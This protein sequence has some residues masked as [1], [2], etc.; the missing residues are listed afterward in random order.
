MFTSL[1]SKIISLIIFIMVVTALIIIFISSREI[2]DAMLVQQDSMSRHVLSL[3]ELNIKGEYSDLISEKIYSVTRHKKQ[4]DSLKDQFIKLLDRLNHDV[5]QQ[6]LSMQD[7][8][9]IALDWVS[10]NQSETSA[11]LFVTDTSLHILGHPDP[12]MKGYDISAFTDI[13]NKTIAQ[14]LAADSTGMNTIVNVVNWEKKGR[15]NS[16]KSLICLK[17][18]HAWNWIVGATVNIENIE[19]EARMALENIIDT[20]NRNLKEITIGSTG[21]AFLFNNT[22]Q[23]LAMPDQTLAG[24]FQISMNSDTGRLL[25]EDMVTA[26]VEDNGDLFYRSDLFKNKE[27][28]AYISFFRPLGWYI[29]VTVPVSETKRP[30][31]EIASKQS[32]LIAMI[33]FF[34]I[35]FTTW[36]VSRISKPLNILA[37]RVKDFSSTDLTRDEAEDTYITT[38]S[39]THNDEV[40]R[41]ASSFA[42]MKKQLKDNIR[43]LI[44]KT[45]E[46]ERIEGELTIARDIQIGLLPK[47]FPPFPE[48]DEIDIFASLEPAKE[49]GGDLYDFYFIEDNLLCFTIGDVSGKGV[50]AALMMAITKTLIK[51]SA[52]KNI[53]PAEIMIEV[54]DVISSDNPQSM[55][56]TLLVGI[57]DVKTGRVCYS[58]GGHNPPILIS[59]SRG[60]CFIKEK[61]GP[62]VGIMNGISY[63]GLELTL[64]PGDSLFMYTDGVT[65]AQNTDKNFYSDPT[66]LSNISGMAGASAETTV[67]TIK[68]DLKTFAGSEPQ[69]DDIAMLMLTYKGPKTPS[70]VSG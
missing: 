7:A 62:M 9:Q 37:G 34:S 8:Q 52:S 20:L 36:L 51:T 22:M 21:F 3:I 11:N 26:A 13:K 33:L 12:D 25:L 47:I 63:K 32:T 17:K 16:P 40:G 60:C 23:V 28:I 48:K 38:L 18:Y 27:M 10:D 58:N 59:K 70:S 44:E 57:L 14:M 49:V 29:G 42:F 66:L 54:N 30:A 64:A 39:E 35:L 31:K 61:S 5:R 1:K 69:F 19:L 4:L 56:V 46:N 2:G 41:L 53:S 45:A 68:S 43:Q 65:E 67:L 24:E 50:P 6:K 55:F 15:S